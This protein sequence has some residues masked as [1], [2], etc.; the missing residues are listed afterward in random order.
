MRLGGISAVGSMGAIDK[1]GSVIKLKGAS[2]LPLYL[3]WDLLRDIWTPRMLWILALTTGAGAGL[4]S[5]PQP[6]I[7]SA[8]ILGV[9]E[10]GGPSGSAALALSLG[11]P[12]P[13]GGG[14]T[15]PELLKGLLTSRTVQSATLHASSGGDPSW[16]DD[17]Q[18]QRE[19]QGTLAEALIAFRAANRVRQDGPTS[20]LYL[21]ARHADSAASERV[22][23]HWIAALQAQQAENAISRVLA[24]QSFT[25]VSLDSTRRVLAEAEREWARFVSRNASYRSVPSSSVEAARLEQRVRQLHETL[26][27]LERSA[28]Q[29]HL[30]E[31]RDRPVVDIIDPPEG[32][33]TRRSML[34]RGIALGMLFGMVVIGPWGW[35]RGVTSYGSVRISTRN[36]ESA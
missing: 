27:S 23:S 25:Q 11:I 6:Y 16:Y 32:S 2:P 17:W 5:R 18:M 24:R 30:D 12:L 19:G 15:S 33:A 14:G 22:L 31:L 1:D 34:R 35:W 26:G 9:R 8:T 3:G 28:L 13:G 21:T 10:E 7:A 36:Q 4:G 29:A 20:M